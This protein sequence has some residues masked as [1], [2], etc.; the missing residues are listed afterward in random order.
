MNKWN[1]IKKS[2]PLLVLAVSMPLQV[3]A[4]DSL[5]YV[6][7]RDGDKEVF[8]LTSEGKHLRMTSTAGDAME[9]VVSPD[10][11][12]LAFT[13][14][15]NGNPDIY[16]M[17]VEKRQPR[18]LFSNPGLDMSPVW[19]PESDKVVFVTDKP[20]SSSILA[21][22]INTGAVEP[23]TDKNTD[24]QP[25]FSPD[26]RY[27]SFVRIN[28]RSK[29]ISVMDL[30][31]K[32]TVQLSA[33]KKFNDG[34]LAWSPD[35]KYLAFTTKRNKKFSLR[36]YEFSGSEL[37]P[38]EKILYEGD[39]KVSGT[40]W[41]PDGKRITFVG[42]PYGKSD[43]EVFT[44]QADG[45]AMLSVGPK[46]MDSSQPRWDS[47]GK[48]ITFVGYKGRKTLLFN[49]NPDGGDLTQLTEDSITAQSPQY[50]RR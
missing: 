10:G 14:L 5:I 8:K 2:T 19:S 31:T 42:I 28:G 38:V 11:K 43:R 24:V 3:F 6:S 22:D 50:V 26:G 23:M 49:I 44:V 27:L 46:A 16:V 37:N 40:N 18:L 21:V 45:S 48:K 7:E 35:G 25:L 4:S 41:S 29:N 20:D 9:P 1:F 33:G 32:K 30:H 34:S 17:N 15:E 39:I 12:W 36:R 13:L 47:E